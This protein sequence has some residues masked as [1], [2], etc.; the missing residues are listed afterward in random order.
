[1]S[2]QKDAQT[3]TV[4]FTED[5]W[6]TIE[7]IAQQEGFPS[8]RKYINHFT[9]EVGSRFEDTSACAGKQGKRM[10]IYQLPRHLAKTFNTLSCKLNLPVS[11]IM[12]ICLLYRVLQHMEADHEGK[13][14]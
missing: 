13:S 14:C 4:Q 5:I 2:Y 9:R 1:M 11:T 10:N 12:S 8:A 6:N 7:E 3:F